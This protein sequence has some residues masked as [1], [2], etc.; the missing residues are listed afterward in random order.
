MKKNPAEVEA[1]LSVRKEVID[2]DFSAKNYSHVVE[3]GSKTSNGLSRKRKRKA[4]GDEDDEDLE[5]RY[6][7]SLSHESKKP[8]TGHNKRRQPEPDEHVHLPA[9]EEISSPNSDSNISI[10]S[11]SHEQLDGL[12][13]QHESLSHSAQSSELEKAS[14]TV[15]LGNVSTITIK[16]KTART[17]LINHLESFLPGLS[18]GD[19]PHKIESIRFR[20]T[21]FSNNGLPKKAAFAKKELM[22][23]TTKSTNAYAIYTTQSAAKEA[24]TKL[25]GTVLFDRHLRVDGV[26]HPAKIDHRRCVFVGNL[27]FVD[28]ESVINAAKDEEENRRP[29]KA[30]E[31][32]DAEEGLWRQFSK[33]G[34]VESVRVIRDKSTRVGKGFAYVQFRVNYLI[35]YVLLLKGFLLTFSGR[36]LGGESFAL[37]R[38]KIPSHAT[39]GFES[40]QG[41]KIIGQHITDQ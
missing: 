19:I 9:R 35:S 30:R 27:G 14:R 10:T 23:S 32:A 17:T 31:P 22:D 25:N 6:L 39:S 20:S 33:A 11:N 40:L 5:S 38:E 12:P 28:D 24:V 8:E 4:N 16:S 21:A 2:N 3:A 34:V 15:F 1:R 18:V 26:A 41:E 37:S 7:Q 13:P 29:R 36:E